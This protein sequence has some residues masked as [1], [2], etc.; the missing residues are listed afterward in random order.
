MA[1]LPEL[2]GAS[3]VALTDLTPQGVVQVRGE[4]WS[5]ESVSGPLP[6]GAAVHALTAR[7]A[8]LE[9]W[10]EAGAVP[11]ANVFYIKEDQP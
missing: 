8:R 5:A 7:G 10:S 6:V 9:V 11:D 3:G 2:R 1:L 4:T